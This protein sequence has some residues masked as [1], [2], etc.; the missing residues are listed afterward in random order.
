MEKHVKIGSWASWQQALG[1]EMNWLQKFAF[2]RCT[3]LL[4][5]A[6]V[7]TFTYTLRVLS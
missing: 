7:E 4:F 1:T 5:H 6:C 3:S 2:Y